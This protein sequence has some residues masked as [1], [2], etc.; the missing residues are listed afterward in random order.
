YLSPC[1]T[2]HAAPH[3]SLRPAVHVPPQRAECRS[4]CRIFNVERTPTVALS[5]AARVSQ[6]RF[7]TFSQR[8]IACRR[9]GTTGAAIDTLPV[10]AA[11]KIPS[12]A[13]VHG[14]RSAP[15]EVTS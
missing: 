12:G 1:G 2:R 5:V 4:R 7:R 6:S 11:L 9:A 3:D 10:R 8:R 14:L 15:L 13:A